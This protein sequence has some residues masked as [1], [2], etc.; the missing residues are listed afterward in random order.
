[1]AT[2]FAPVRT[3]F[4]PP[5]P[6]N[7]KDL[8][9]PENLLLDLILRRMLIE[10]YCSLE[11]LSRALR[12]SIPIVDTIFKHMRQQQLVEIKGMLGNDYHFVLSQAGKQLANERF[13]VSQYA[14]ACP[15]SLNDYSAATKAQV[16]GVM[17]RGSRRQIPPPART[18][19]LKATRCV[20]PSSANCRP[21]R[22]TKS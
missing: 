13:Q 15:V 22:S 2:T 11:S 5:I 8:G 19:A 7:F 1:M 4:H 17:S 20:V 9:I 14:G 10:G 6:Q 16:S 3:S 18:Q 12:V 21:W